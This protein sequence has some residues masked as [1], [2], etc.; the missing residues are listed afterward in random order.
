MT[1]LQDTCVSA[2]SLGEAR[3]ELLKELVGRFALA[4]VPSGQSAVMQR[5]ALGLGDQSLDEWPQ[6]L[7]L[8]LGR[9]DCLFLDQRR[10]QIA[11]QSDPLLA[12]PAQLPASLT[13]THCPMSP[14]LLPT[15]SR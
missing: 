1:G 11:Q 6:L 15:H 2:G 3:S 13:M 9:H 14:L 8:G 10:G 4:H 7:C 5:P 12:G